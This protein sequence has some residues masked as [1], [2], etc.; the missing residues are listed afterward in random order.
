MIGA[1]VLSSMAAFRTGAGLVTVGLPRGLIKVLQKRVAP[2][3]MVLPLPQTSEQTVS[4]KAADELNAKQSTYSAMGI[5]PGLSQEE[6][7]AKF[8]TDALIH[9]NLPVVVDADALNILAADVSLLKL[10]SAPTVL[11]PHP[12][13]M[14][15]L[16]GHEVPQ[17]ETGRQQLA[18]EFAH[19]SGCVVVLKGHRTV[20]ADALEGIYSNET[21]NVGMATAGSGDVLSGIITALLAQGVEAGEAA[22]F[23]VYLHGMAADLAVQTIDPV[24]LMASDIIAHISPALGKIRD[25]LTN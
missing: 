3:V 13:E 17:D 24:S 10:R 11:T 8:V 1:A 25:N 18:I 22:R 4:A 21:G 19:T 15:R 7:T 2:E 20:V 14:S 9:L 23:G 5:G 16:I 12:G 6:S